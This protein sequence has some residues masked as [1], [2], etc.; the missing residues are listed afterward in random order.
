MEL[1][2]KQA[3]R[4][5]LLTRNGALAYPSRAQMIANPRYFRMT[6]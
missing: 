1:S 5:H 6:G 3:Q 4:W 2:L